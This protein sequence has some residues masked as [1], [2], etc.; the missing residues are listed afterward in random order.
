MGIVMR[1]SVIGLTLGRFGTRF[2]ERNSAPQTIFHPTG[3]L[4]ELHMNS[5]I[6]AEVVTFIPCCLVLDLGRLSGAR[7]RK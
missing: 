1:M 7:E 5:P 3:Q 2:I 6:P 4:A